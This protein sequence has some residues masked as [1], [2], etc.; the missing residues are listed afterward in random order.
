MVLIVTVQMVTRK[1]HRANWSPKC[2][3]W[4]RIWGSWAFHTSNCSNMRR[5]TTCSEN[6]ALF[7]LS[8]FL[9]AR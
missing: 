5:K 7:S 6:F 4:S 2:S 1:W 8:W 3:S 9:L